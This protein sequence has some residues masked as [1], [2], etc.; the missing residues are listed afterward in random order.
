VSSFIIYPAAIPRPRAAKLLESMAGKGL[1][2]RIRV[3][4][5]V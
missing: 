4:E 2:F 3:G 1:I 5:D